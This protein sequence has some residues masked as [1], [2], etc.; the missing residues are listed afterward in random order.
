MKEASPWVQLTD[1]TEL[2]YQL[3]Q[4]LYANDGDRWVVFC[5]W[6]LQNHWVNTNSFN[7]VIFS[8]K[9]WFSNNYDN[10]I[11][12]KMKRG[13]FKK[14]LESIFGRFELVF[15]ETEQFDEYC[16]KVN[17]IS[18]HIVK[19]LYSKWNQGLS[20]TVLRSIYFEQDEAPHHNIK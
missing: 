1:M 6:L 8:D 5:D 3:Y 18:N 12:I 17:W 19:I 9:S 4:H 15:P 2:K 16:F 7:F 11:N 20:L 13:I 14:D 10:K